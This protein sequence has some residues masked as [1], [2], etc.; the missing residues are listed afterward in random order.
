MVSIEIRRFLLAFAVAGLII[1]T[2][3]GKNVVNPRPDSD[4]AFNQDSPNRRTALEQRSSDGLPTFHRP[5]TWQDTRG[6]IPYEDYRPDQILVLFADELMLPDDFDGFPGSGG[7]PDYNA[8]S[9]LYQNKTHAEFARWLA[10]KYSLTVLPSQEAYVPGFNF[11]AYQLSSGAIAEDVM[12]EILDENPVNVR[13]VE[14]NAI[15]EPAYIPDD[16][17]LSNQW[18]HSV[19]DSYSAWDYGTGDPNVWTAVI[20]T[21]VSLSHP[22]LAENIVPV[23]NLF[24][25]ERFDHVDNDIFP[26]DVSGH[27][28][29]VAGIASALGDNATGVAG[30]AYNS[31]ILPVRALGSGAGLGT[32]IAGI[33]LSVSIDPPADVINLSLAGY[34]PS[35][36]EKEACEY[37]Y[38]NGTIVVAAAGNEDNTAQISF[39]AGV[40]AVI[41][42]GATDKNDSRTYYSN[43]GWWVDIVAPGGKQPPTSDGILSTVLS[44]YNY[45]Q[46]TSMA[47]PM[48]AGAAALLKSINNS[49]SNDQYR[50]FLE[51]SGDDLP[52]SEWG[53]VL[54]KR[55]NIYKALSFPLSDPPSIQI[56]SP[57]SGEQVSGVETITFN[58]TDDRSTIYP[59]L[60]INGL[61]YGQGAL[62]YEV[63]F[64][65]YLPGEVN[66]IAEVIDEDH[67]HAFDEVTVTVENFQVSTAPYYNNF[68]TQADEWVVENFS[69]SGSWQLIGSV[70]KSW[71]LEYGAD[72]V[73]WL[74]GPVIDLTPF[75]QA[76]IVFW[77][78]W[79]LDPARPFFVGTY[80]PPYNVEDLI[81]TYLPEEWTDYWYEVDISA[82]AGKMIKPYFKLDHYF[83]G[84]QPSSGN[85]DVDEFY[86]GVPTPAPNVE[87]LEPTENARVSATTTIRA[88]ASDDWRVE[89][90]VFVVEGNIV[91]EDFV[92]PYEVNFNSNQYPNGSATIEA[93]AYDYDW[94]DQDGYSG[95]FDSNF[96]TSNVI[97]RNQA[98]IGMSPTSGFYGE[99]VLIS[100]F[101]FN[102]YKAEAGRRVVF[103]GEG[104]EIDAD[105]VSW[106]N[107]AITALVP[108]GAVTGKVRVY[109]DESYAESA[110]PFTIVNPFTDLALQV[111]DPP[112]NMMFT[113]NFSALA[114]AQPDLDSL[115]L[116]IIGYPEKIW[117]RDTLGDNSDQ[118]FVVDITG[119]STGT[120]LLRLTG[121]Y[122]SYTEYVELTF[123][124]NTLPG[125]FNGD[126]VVDDL[127]VNVLWDYLNAEGIVKEGD[128]DFVPYLEVSGDGVIDEQDA[129]L[130]GYWFGDTI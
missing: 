53:S 51:A 4:R 127:D 128:A 56:T 74:I 34:V 109:I 93:H 105:V 33:I 5:R 36:V 17:F 47:S 45:Y 102:H 107:E 40:P 10:N 86:I 2:T 24:P 14:Y 91:G 80:A 31:S 106:T 104:H 92:P 75:P 60:Y 65:N 54:T 77:G 115:T 67:Q 125:D 41:A 57:V 118:S 114:S 129:S 130:I 61:Y 69:G 78:T 6:F 22:D 126:H 98:I 79:S 64:T 11:S 25:T 72:D 82:S 18:H 35:L 99:H 73:D 113:D 38:L 97:I 27:G 55:L 76:K 96:V 46:G 63:D 119:L 9:V 85:I 87:I 49:Y 13:I 121:R 8:N 111:V 66:I 26:N 100:G 42:V 58:V 52:D 94:Y 84:S 103:A 68:D 95:Y 12:Q 16:T 62:S 43:Y 15:R 19:I 71:R 39:P 120:Y 1:L 88:D 90:V 29:H 23:W 32:I 81:G 50:A 117:T 110:S 108:V 70:D 37:A 30:I 20:D 101:D 59:I 28:T 48:V 124:L 89:I 21:G 123:Y 116:E 3:C 112:S 44:D 7:Q 122:G 83:S